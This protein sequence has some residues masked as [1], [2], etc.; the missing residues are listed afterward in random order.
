MTIVLKISIDELSKLRNKDSEY[1]RALFEDI[2]PY[3]FKVLAANK[4]F[5]EFAGELIQETWRI[6]FE[7]LDQFE[8]RSQIK[9]YVTG[10]LINKVREHRRFYKKM[11]SEENSDKIF[12]QSFTQDGWWI[13]APKDPHALIQSA[14][15]M[16]F[17]EECLEGLSDSQKDAFV[18]K[19]IDQEI[20]A[21]ICNILN[22]SVTHLGVLIFRAKEKLRLCLE[23]KI[24]AISNEI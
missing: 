19:E 15:T 22:V 3:L 21:E 10:I 5:T 7:N 24:G 2:N 4:I 17:I 11:N 23:G 8:G 16:N 20:T 9:T 14:E 1:L 13:N 6:F 12:E 18:L